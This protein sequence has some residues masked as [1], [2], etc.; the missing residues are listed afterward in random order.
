MANSETVFRKTKELHFKLGGGAP[1]L[2]MNRLHRELMLRPEELRRH[3]LTLKGQDL[4]KF[5]DSTGSAITVTDLGQK[6][7]L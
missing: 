7:T 3:I 4:I 2:T 1:V 5:T 6:T